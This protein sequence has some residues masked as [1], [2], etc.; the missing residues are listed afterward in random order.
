[1]TG[2]D[3]K[4]LFDNIPHDL[5][6]KA[7]KKHAQCKWILLY[8]EMAHRTFTNPRRAISCQNERGAARWGSV[9]LNCI[10]TK[11]RL[12][13]AKM[14]GANKITVIQRLIFWAIVFGRDWLNIARNPACLSVL[15]QR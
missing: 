5:L 15:L 8:I 2:Y 13:T 6:L 7:V 3:I 4:G 11:L 12:F 14:E 1:M 10:Q 9:V